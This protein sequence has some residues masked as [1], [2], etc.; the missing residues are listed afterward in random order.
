MSE[1]LNL[2]NFDQKAVVKD[3]S[4]MPPTNLYTKQPALR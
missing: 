4:I 3:F 2:N 1:F